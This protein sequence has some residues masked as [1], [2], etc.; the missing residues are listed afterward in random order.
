MRT[1][2]QVIAPVLP[3]TLRKFMR[4]RCRIPADAFR[5]LAPKD[6]PEPARRLLVHSQ[7]MTSTLAAFHES[8]LRVQL[9]QRQRENDLYLR[10]VFLRTQSGDAI[11]E[12]GV[13]AI[14]LEQFTPT[15]QDA[16]EA[17]QI[18]LGALLHR[19]KIAFESAPIG[20]FSTSGE[21][22]AGTALHSPA[23]STCYGRFN[24]LSKPTAEPLAWILE[25]LPPTE[26]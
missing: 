6:V 18:P 26:R 10:E 1:V 20:F 8:P 9:L 21:S 13:I 15:Q 7:D 25:I 14:A 23:D 5:P 24:R 11:V 17:G 22:L 4:E 2:E 19:F 12:Y 16:I 3:E